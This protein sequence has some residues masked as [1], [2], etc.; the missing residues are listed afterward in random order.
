VRVHDTVDSRRWNWNVRL[1][2]AS[3]SR[4]LSENA[5]LTHSDRVCDAV[6]RDI[7]LMKH[8]HGRRGKDFLE[9][10]RLS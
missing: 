9:D 1:D 4:R 8:V 10:W 2:F 3:T 6:D 5:G 7:W